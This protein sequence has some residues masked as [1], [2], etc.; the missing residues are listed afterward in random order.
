MILSIL[1]NY[2]YYIS[3]LIENLLKVISLSHLLIQKKL[4]NH[5]IK[6]K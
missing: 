2:K 3:L 5:R 1:Q 6:Q 4:S